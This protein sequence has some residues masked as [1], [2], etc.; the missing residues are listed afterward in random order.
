MGSPSTTTVAPISAKHTIIPTEIQLNILAWLTKS[1][2]NPNESK[3]RL[4][5]YARVC[6]GWQSIVEQESFRHLTLHA[7]DIE[8]FERHVRPHRRGYVKH[9]LLEICIEDCYDRRPLN[10]GYTDRKNSTTFTLA[11]WRL[12]QVLVTWK[13]HRLTVEL[14]ILSS[15]E[16]RL[17][18]LH[19]EENYWPKPWSLAQDQ[20]G[21]LSM[22]PH[23]DH[24]ATFNLPPTDGMFIIGWNWQ[25]SG[26][27]GRAPVEFNSNTL[28]GR[29]LPKV[30]V[31]ARLLIRRRYFCNVSPNTLA[32]IFGSAPYTEVIHVERWCYGMGRRDSEWDEHS[33]NL[34]HALSPSLKRF[35]FFEE[36][37]TPYHQ[38]SGRMVL[39]RSNT[40]LLNSLTETGRHLEHISISFAI[41]AQDFFLPQQQLDFSLLITLALTSETMTSRSAV[42][43]NELLGNAARAVKKMPKL[44]LLEIW[45]YKTG[46]TGIFVYEKLDRCSE[47]TWQGTW[48]FQISQEVK[49]TWWE[50]LAD[51]DGDIFELSV[52]HVTLELD[53]LTSLASI[54]PY[55]KLREHILDEVSWTQV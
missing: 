33:E 3:P 16:R 10:P 42:M 6:K 40:R 28:L 46:E 41:D 54:F 50:V 24:L 30:E 17:A 47:I 19:N 43:V 52:R 39:P 14:G 8:C 20:G 36:Y 27:L 53:Q 13:D 18:S 29:D 5:N 4:S 25:R 38:R 11:V 35:S 15:F 34:V 31:I 37:S 23:I 21:N 45:N 7:S 48:D 44:K 26:L 1:H 9:I 12:W 32:Q 55:L 51:S 49:D 22:I 2:W